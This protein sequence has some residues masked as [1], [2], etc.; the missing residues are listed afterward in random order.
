MLSSD[1]LVLL[2]GGAVLPYVAEA[3]W[4]WARSRR[5]RRA[6]GGKRCN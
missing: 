2:G 6:A 1:L 5:S 4:S 3:V